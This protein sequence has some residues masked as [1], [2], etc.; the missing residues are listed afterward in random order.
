MVHGL[1]Q[2]LCVYFV[3]FWWSFPNHYAQAYMF[4]GFFL[5]AM[6][7]HTVLQ[8]VLLL[9]SVAAPPKRWFAIYLWVTVPATIL[10]GYSQPSM[11]VVLASECLLQLSCGRICDSTNA[12]ASPIVNT[13]PN[14]NPTDSDI[15]LFV[16][17]KHC[18]WWCPVAMQVHLNFLA[19]VL[20]EPPELRLPSPDL[21]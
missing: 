7:L 11:C 1:W 16:K 2:S 14:T 4:W 20:L 17:C 9:I 13:S 12:S 5:A 10:C 21:Q 6:T 15:C 19:G 18:G 8:S 3:A